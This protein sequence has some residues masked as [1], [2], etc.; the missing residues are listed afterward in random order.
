MWLEALDR[1]RTTDDPPTSAEPSAGPPPASRWARR[2]PEAAARLE[3]VRTGI[4]ELSQRISVPTE[5]II[6]PEIVRRLCWDWQPL[7]TLEE[8]AAV[9][10]EFLREARV[11]RWQRELTVPV[12]SEA[13]Y[14][15]PAV[16]E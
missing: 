4:T 6:T 10:D 5:N 12:L 3:A 7:P 1:A 14:A 2:K 13:L 15:D 8:T 16:P 9:I 11:R